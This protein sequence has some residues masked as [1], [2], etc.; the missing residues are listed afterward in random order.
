METGFLF[1]Q[2][3]LA[4][5]ILYLHKAPRLHSQDYLVDLLFRSLDFHG[6]RTAHAAKPRTKWMKNGI[7]GL[8]SKA[9][10][11]FAIKSASL[12]R[13]QA[14]FEHTELRFDRVH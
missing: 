7:L 14:T 11:R 12:E 5:H 4:L 13:G 6:D 8:R 10:G 3:Y 2:N 1:Y 9:G